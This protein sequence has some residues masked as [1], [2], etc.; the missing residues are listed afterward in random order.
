MNFLQN[1]IK[2]LMNNNT[3]INSNPKNIQDR[4]INDTLTNENEEDDYKNDYYS[5][6][7]KQIKPIFNEPKRNEIKAKSSLSSF[8][9]AYL[10][11]DRLQPRESFLEQEKSLITT[12]RNHVYNSHKNTS[13]HN[14]TH[15]QKDINKT[16]IQENIK[17]NKHLLQEKSQKELKSN[18]SLNQLKNNVALMNNNNNFKNKESEDDLNSKYFLKIGKS[19]SPIKQDYR[20]YECAEKKRDL[21]AINNKNLSEVMKFFLIF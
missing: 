20:N 10:A 1:Q 9:K 13:F 2:S 11:T 5:K 15:H 6:A 19:K 7:N 4:K 12:D 8:E 18:G 17:A 14:D 21:S 3:N 16:K